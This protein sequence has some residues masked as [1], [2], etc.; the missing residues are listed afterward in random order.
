MDVVPPPVV[1]EANPPRQWWTWVLFMALVSCVVYGNLT[2]YFAPSQE[3]TDIIASEKAMIEPAIRSKLLMDSVAGSSGEMSALGSGDAQLFEV[4]ADLIKKIDQSDEA[5]AWVLAIDNL[6]GRQQTDRAI[7][8]LALTDSEKWHDFGVAFDGSLDDPAVL[9]GD[10]I[11]VKIARWRNEHPTL[12]KIPAKEIG[13]TVNAPL[14]IGFLGYL[15]M[16]IFGGVIV[17]VTYTAMKFSGML[18]AKGYQ[19]NISWRGFDARGARMGIYFSTFLILSLGF[20]LIAQQKLISE[21][22]GSA[23]LMLILIALTPLFATA[24]SFGDKIKYRE[25]IGDTSE[26]WKKLLWGFCGYMA[27]LPIAFALLIGMTRL[28]P[29]MPT[30][31]HEVIEMVKTSTG[32]SMFLLFFM[33]A[34]AAPLVEEPM[35]RGVLF[36]SLQKLFK[37]PTAA[38]L[39]TGVVFA[40]IH[41]QGPLVWPALAV[42]GMTAAIMTRQTGSLI[43]AITMHALHNATLFA[44]S[45]VMVK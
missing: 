33:V 18:P 42:V 22:V 27:N 43:P 2:A 30:P 17:L 28:F 5:A 11:L 25:I 24:K 20:S 31:S 4:R 44:F 34:I 38:I 8:R 41:M 9:S 21:V 13:M 32:L 7:D 37:S 6:L 45:M 29:A 36:P 12:N 23:I 16:V 40:V 26:I 35:F 3:P 10:E 15:M 1:V 19:S 39:L 14:F